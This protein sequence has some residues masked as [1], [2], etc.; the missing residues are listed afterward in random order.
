MFSLKCKDKFFLKK[1]YELFLQKKIK[2]STNEN[3]LVCLNFEIFEGEI[4]LKFQDKCLRTNLPLN[5]NN[6]F[7]FI[8][9]EINDFN[10]RFGEYYFFPF[11]RNILGNKRKTLLSDIQN[12]IILFLVMNNNVLSKEI[13]YKYIWPNDKNISLNKLDTHLTNLKNQIKNDLKLDLNFHSQEK[14]LQLLI[15]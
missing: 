4:R 2:V 7:N 11:Q 6:L 3:F 15:N 8:S 5:L 9:K 12:N 14:N 10:I 13:L 1:I